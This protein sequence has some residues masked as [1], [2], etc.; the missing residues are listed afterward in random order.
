MAF[1]NKILRITLVIILPF[2]LI[3]YLFPQL[4]ARVY[5]DSQ[6]LI[7]SSLPTIKIIAFAMIF[8]GTGSIIFSCVSGTGNTRTAFLFEVI[9][10]AFYLSYV[11]ITAIAMKTNVEIVWLSEFAYWIILSVLGYVYMVSNKWKKKEI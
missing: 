2:T 1:L 11:Y 4:P 10:L 8:C 7:Y 6:N 3:T 5:T 9:T